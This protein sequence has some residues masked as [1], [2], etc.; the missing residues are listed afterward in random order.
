[1]ITLPDERMETLLA[2]VRAD[3]VRTILTEKADHLNLLT[4]AQVCG[5]LNI[6]QKTL[7]TIRAIP[8][9]I[10]IPGSVIRY[11]LS[12]VEAFISSRAE[13]VPTPLDLRAAK[14]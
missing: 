11:R 2:E 4:G 12:D 7:D 6:N 10:I 9:V 5:I 8:R 3:L 1:M 14:D 13:P